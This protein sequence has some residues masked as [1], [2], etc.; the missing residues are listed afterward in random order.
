VL[1][2]GSGCG[3]GRRIKGKGNL[4]SKISKM[5]KGRSN[6]SANYFC[7]SFVVVMKLS[8]VFKSL[9]HFYLSIIAT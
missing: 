7:R 5:S 9:K 3:K 1:P 8:S 6:D 4:F 2:K